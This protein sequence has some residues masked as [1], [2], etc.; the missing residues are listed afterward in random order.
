LARESACAC[1]LEHGC[2]RRGAGPLAT[3]GQTDAAARNR[4]KFDTFDSTCR[5]SDSGNIGGTDTDSSVGHVG[6]AAY[7]TAHDPGSAADSEPDSRTDCV[8]ILGGRGSGAA[9]TTRASGGTTDVAADAA[10]SHGA[11]EIGTHLSHGRG[12]IRPTTSD[13]STIV[14]PFRIGH[15]TTPKPGDG[16]DLGERRFPAIGR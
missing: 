13:E 12:A 9:S 5:D 16:C 3:R 2:S 6:R 11:S 4:T 15:A 10:S 7:G 1:G 8:A 14:R